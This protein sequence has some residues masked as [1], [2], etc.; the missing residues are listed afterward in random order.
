MESIKNGYFKALFIFGM[1]SILAKIYK[2]NC[3]YTQCYSHQSFAVGKNTLWYVVI[4]Q[5]NIILI[6]KMATI[7]A[8][9]SLKQMLEFWNKNSTTV[10]PPMHIMNS[11]NCSRLKNHM[12]HSEVKQFLLGQT[13]VELK[14]IISLYRQAGCLKVHIVLDIPQKVTR[15]LRGGRQIMHQAF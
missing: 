11:L 14:Q 10:L 13:C 5:D 12:A 1:D 4:W 15:S 8:R 2:G 9:C 6:S 3:N 7:Y